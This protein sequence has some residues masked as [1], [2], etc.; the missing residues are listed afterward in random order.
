[1]RRYHPDVPFFVLLADEEGG[2][3]SQLFE[4]LTLPDL[5]IPQLERFLFRY[6]KQELKDA[7]TPF[8]IAAL[9]DRSFRRVA[10]F[11]QESLV[12][13][14]LTSVLELIGRA[15]IRCSRLDPLAPLDGA[16]RAAELNILQSG[17]YNVGFI[18]VTGTPTG[19]AFLSVVAVA[20]G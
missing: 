10:F 9:L 8:L 6:E 1:M 16:D 19:R 4:V 13:G 17:I 11:K 14:D 15:S 18:G 7:A 12:T 20:D 2:I 5:A 3:G